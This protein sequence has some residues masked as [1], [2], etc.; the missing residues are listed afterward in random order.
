MSTESNVA[1]VRRLIEAVENGRNVELIDELIAPDFRSHQLWHQPITP[2][3]LKPV[4]ERA[5][6]RDF[7]KQA[8]SYADRTFPESH[9]TIDEIL[10]IDDR[11]VVRATTEVTHHSGKR[12]RWHALGI[13]RIA[14][15]Q[16]AELWQQW[17]RLG[18]FQ[19]LG[20][21]PPTSELL[22]QIGDA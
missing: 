2:E 7:M 4:S 11:V 15:G 6:E 13:Y 12:A 19:Q 22:A 3:E 9:I 20:V 17:D 21:I 16:V 8:A 1:L 18:Y 5:S 10:A 14:A